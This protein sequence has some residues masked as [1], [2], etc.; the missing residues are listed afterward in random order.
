ML[1]PP[2]WMLQLAMA[3]GCC[4]HDESAVGNSLR[5]SRKLLGILE[6]GGGVYS[7]FGFRVSDVVRVY[8]AQFQETEVAHCSSSGANVQR[9]ARRYQNYTQR[10]ML[11]S[12]MLR[13]DAKCRTN[14]TCWFPPVLCKGSSTTDVLPRSH[15]ECQG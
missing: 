15:T 3:N 5:H 7:R 12:S 14:P 9:I 6:E 8:Y 11:H 2:E 10:I 13:S 4:A 1:H